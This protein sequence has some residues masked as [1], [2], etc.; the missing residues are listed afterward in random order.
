MMTRSEFVLRRKKYDLG[1]A[2]LDPGFRIGATILITWLILGSFVIGFVSRRFSMDITES[3]Q[4]VLWFVVLLALFFV[5]R[6]LVSRDEG[7]RARH[8]GLTCPNCEAMLVGNLGDL[9]VASGRCG[10]CGAI[11][12]ASDDDSGDAKASQGAA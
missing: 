11:V 5:T 8:A 9:A 7:R 2:I 6:L 1:S 3:Q 10:R 4:S 12:L